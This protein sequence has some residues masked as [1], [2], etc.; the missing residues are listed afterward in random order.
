MGNNKSHQIK[1]DYLDRIVIIKRCGILNRI[2]RY[3]N[4]FLE[5]KQ[6]KIEDQ[7]W[8][9]H[10]KCFKNGNILIVDNKNDH[11][12]FSV[13][14]TDGVP[15]TERKLPFNNGVISHL[16]LY[17]HDDTFVLFLL[18][19]EIDSIYESLYVI[20][21]VGSEPK[22]IASFNSY[23]PVYFRLFIF[24]GI[25]N[26]LMI[27]YDGHRVVKR[28]KYNSVFEEVSLDFLPKYFNPI[29]HRYY[30]E[31]NNKNNFSRLMVVYHHTL[32]D[33]YVIRIISTD[34][35]EH[36]IIFRR[37][38]YHGGRCIFSFDEHQE[39]IIAI[40]LLHNKLLIHFWKEIGDKIIYQF[41]K[42]YNN[43]YVCSN[44]RLNPLDELFENTQIFCTP[45]SIII[46]SADIK[47][48]DR[49]S[50]KIIHHIHR[51]STDTLCILNVDSDWNNKVR[52]L[53][54]DCHV[55]EKF[56]VDVLK[57]IL[58]FFKN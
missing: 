18:C 29:N 53:M 46:N 44:K 57:I 32:T 11:L 15:I 10:Y 27:T 42:T 14:D 41:N 20:D 16:K 28:Y 19:K 21:F 8:S 7:S 12:L 50:L 51:C 33:H 34:N 56:S 49:N 43:K 40:E 47:I 4:N 37:P 54:L 38:N 24:E 48:I 2:E 25:P 9:K 30:I 13:I 5:E 36:E 26:I 1:H 45:S 31:I 6:T 3:D 23:N 58:S 17:E 52:Q 55:M 22:I 39:M 35:T